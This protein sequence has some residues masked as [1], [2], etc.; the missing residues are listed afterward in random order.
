VA[1][2]R[3]RRAGRIGRRSQVVLALGLVIEL[4]WVLPSD[5]DEVP[6]DVLYTTPQGRVSWLDR[7]VLKQALRECLYQVLWY[8]Y[9]TSNLCGTQLAVAQINEFF[10]RCLRLPKGQFVVEYWSDTERN[11]VRDPAVSCSRQPNRRCSLV[12]SMDWQ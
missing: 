2:W 9:C 4:K 5:P 10:Y 11:E 7:D 1:I 6:S 12:D 3:E 8:L